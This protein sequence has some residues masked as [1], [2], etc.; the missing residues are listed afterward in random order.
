M[1]CEDWTAAT[2][3]EETLEL[4]AWIDVLCHHYPIDELK[5]LGE[6]W[7]QKYQ[8]AASAKSW[9]S[10]GGPAEGMPAVTAHSAIVDTSMEASGCHLHMERQLAPHMQSLAELV[11]APELAAWT[12]SWQSV[13]VASCTPMIL[14]SAASS[15]Q[16]T[17]AKHFSLDYHEMLTGE[18][19]HFP[20]HPHVQG[21]SAACSS[22]QSQSYMASQPQ[23]P[24]QPMTSAECEAGYSQAARG[25]IEQIERQINA[26]HMMHYNLSRVPIQGGEHQQQLP[27]V[28]CPDVNLCY[29]DNEDAIAG[30]L[31]LLIAVKLYLQEKASELRVSI[32]EIPPPANP[33]S[34]YHYVFKEGVDRLIEGM[35]QIIGSAMDRSAVYELL[36][37]LGD[38]KRK[39]KIDKLF[40]DL[41]T[42]LK[43]KESVEE[44]RA[45]LQKLDII[46][47]L[48]LPVDILIKSR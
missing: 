8:G 21:F 46:H 48:L 24:S 11:D 26:L 18:Q 38:E 42:N 12:S 1:R 37:Q 16:S 34:K 22:V 30:I 19:R 47:K 25:I 36:M 43:V 31:S 2:F 20:I 9:V 15:L 32:P 41:K 39:S 13:P 14:P 17:S 33:W 44:D 28:W 7:K 40:T 45:V 29:L 4:L 10:S 27:L 6:A 3:V 23:H 35:Q 5:E